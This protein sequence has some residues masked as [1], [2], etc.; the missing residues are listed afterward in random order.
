APAM[1][2]GRGARGAGAAAWRSGRA[3]RRRV[4][5]AARPPSLWAAG[6]LGYNL[7]P[8]APGRWPRA[9]ITFGV[10]RSLASA[11]DWGSRGRRFKSYHPDHLVRPRG[12]DGGAGPADGDASAAAPRAGARAC[13]APIAASPGARGDGG[14]RRA[15]GCARAPA[16]GG[17]GHARAGR[18]RAGRRRPRAGPTPRRA[19][20]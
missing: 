20:T 18:G 13:A 17:C 9:V 16:R 3:E 4:T 1:A 19:P 10:W 6:P 7:A 2:A 14:H 5:P 12:R 8:P 15:D 11:L